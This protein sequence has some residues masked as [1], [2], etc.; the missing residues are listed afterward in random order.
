MRG[1][2]RGVVGVTIGGGRKGMLAAPVGE[3]LSTCDHERGGGLLVH[4]I[5]DERT[6][7][8]LP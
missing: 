6:P 1:G 2:V 3:V 7:A 5:R 8:T 4:D